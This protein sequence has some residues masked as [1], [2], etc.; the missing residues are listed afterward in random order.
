MALCGRCC[1]YPQG[2]ISFFPTMMALAGLLCTFYALP[3]TPGEWFSGVHF[4][5][6]HPE[7][8]DFSFTCLP[9]ILVDTDY[10]SS[11]SPDEDE[12]KQYWKIQVATICAI[13]AAVIG[14]IA[15]VYLFGAICFHLEKGMLNRIAAGYTACAAFSALTF[16]AASW[17]RCA[18]LGNTSESCKTVVRLEKGAVAEIF[19]AFFFLAA[20]VATLNFAQS[21]GTGKVPGEPEPSGT[22]K[23]SDEVLPLVQQHSNPPAPRVETP[24]TSPRRSSRPEGSNGLLHA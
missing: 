8:Q 14:C 20:A 22:M 13:L 12:T 16:I 23:S 7:D 24:P 6:V 2:Q 10:W 1:S 4:I 5:C 9:L 15:T 3:W 17:D 11:G 21:V 19:A 18:Q